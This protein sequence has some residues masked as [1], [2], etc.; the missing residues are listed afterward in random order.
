MKRVVA[1]LLQ[2]HKTSLQLLCLFKWYGGDE[3]KEVCFLLHHAQNGSFLLLSGRIWHGTK[4]NN[5]DKEE[6]GPFSL[7]LRASATKMKMPSLLLL[8]PSLSS[9][10]VE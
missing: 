9:F 3:E 6:R 1:L 2:Q 5:N 8:L 7:V 10:T 4:N